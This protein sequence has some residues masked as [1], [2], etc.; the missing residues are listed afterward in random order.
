MITK[1]I[2]MKIHD[3]SEFFTPLD[4]DQNMISD[5]VVEYFSR[6]FLAKHRKLHEKYV[7]RILS[8]TSVDEEHIKS[9][10]KSEFEQKRDDLHYALKK[11]TVKMIVLAIL[12]V[13]I[14]SVWFYLLLTTESIA[15]EILSIMAWVCIWEA[16][17][18]LIMERPELIATLK[19]IN[20]LLNSDIRVETIGESAD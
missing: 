7:I 11:L 8:E 1:E 9:G 12:G 10:I 15:V 14:L 19:S 13:L 18:I 3:E 5:D 16:T 17:S 2:K 6:V 4:P 20:K